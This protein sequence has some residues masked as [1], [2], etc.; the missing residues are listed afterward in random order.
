M[1]FKKLAAI[2]LFALGAGVA[3]ADPIQGSFNFT[4]TGN[5]AGSTCVGDTSAP[6]DCS[7]TP[8]GGMGGQLLQWGTESNPWDLQSALRI[9]NSGGS[10]GRDFNHDG[11]YSDVG[12]SMLGSIGN[13]IVT[14]GGWTNISAFEHYNNII[15]MAG[16]QINMVQLLA[17]LTIP[18]VALP[19]PWGAGGNLVQFTESQNGQTCSTPTPNSTY[20]D[21][22]FTGLSL[23]GGYNF[24]V[25]G[26]TYRLSLQFVAGPGAT[27][28]PA[29][30]T[31]IDGVEFT[32]WVAYTSEPCIEFNPNG[33]CKRFASGGEFNAAT[34]R[35]GYSVIFTQARIDVVPEPGS[36]A[37]LGLGLLGL[38]LRRRFAA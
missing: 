30:T 22:F 34:Y 32:N 5:F 14:N 21:D 37:L 31:I 7:I 13:N 18:G 23:E 16:G 38:G 25:G 11:D 17:S 24:T 33:T 4:T 27:L 19:P 28:V 15:L 10:Y 1:N 8:P 26:N 35:P 9:V 2:G 12:E 36:L 6:N 3:Q 29:G 20:C